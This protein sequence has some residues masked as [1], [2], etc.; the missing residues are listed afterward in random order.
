[1]NNKPNDSGLYFL[2]STVKAIIA[3]LLKILLFPIRVLIYRNNPLNVRR[4]KIL[5]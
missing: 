5:K 4:V 2:L 3:L 1:M